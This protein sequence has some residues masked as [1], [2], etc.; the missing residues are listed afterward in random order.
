MSTT[1][2][3]DLKHRFAEYSST[4]STPDE[5]FAL[6]EEA[7]GRCPVPHT[8]TGGG[9]YL[10]LDYED[11]K[12][13]HA[14]AERFSNVPGIMRPVAD[15]PQLPPLEYD[16]P[17]HKHW[18]SLFTEAANPQTPARI[19]GAVRADVAR[20]IDA[21]ASTGSCDLVEEFAVP[22][23]LYALCHMLGLETARAAEF[24][25][26]AEA[27]IEGFNDVEKGPIAIGA[28]MEYGNMLVAERQA[29]PRE[30]YLTW[31][32]TAEFDGRPVGPMEIG[33]V[34]VGLLVAGHDTSVSGL[35][36]CLYEVLSRP[37]IKQQLLDDPSLI[38]AAVDEAL[39]LHPPFIGFFRRATEAVNLGG[40]Q[41]PADAS[42]QIV[43]AAANRD[44]KVFEDPE[45]VRLDR[46]PG[47][48]RHLTFGFG[49]HA[50]VGQPTAR[51]EMRIAL[52][53]ILRRLPDIHLVDP[54][55]VKYEFLGSE[56]QAITKLAARFTPES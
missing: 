25:R 20:L 18:R 14:D 56:A 6:F 42:L 48:N 29:N 37:D 36:S 12:A 35:T 51:M 55:S 2:D 23:P 34:M 54:D 50:C 9:F 13:V 47:R 44:P 45:E 53:E 7:R 49:A 46:K 28:L 43:W 10:V 8:E 27:F 17:E 41:I 33:L 26:L 19:E 39:R 52:E 5:A 40:T 16:A 22:I 31:L 4:T 3:H 30:D 15:R 38:P 24:R 1:E 32:G 11:A 21:F